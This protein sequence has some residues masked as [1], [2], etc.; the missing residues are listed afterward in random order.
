[1]AINVKEFI[2]QAKFGLGMSENAA[3]TITDYD[4]LKKEIIEECMEQ[5][6]AYLEKKEGR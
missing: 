5:I 4:D 6:E 3:P 1:M 2:I